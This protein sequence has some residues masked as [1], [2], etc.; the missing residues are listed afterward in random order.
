[1]PGWSRSS[2]L[3]KRQLFIREAPSHIE[4]LF[5]NERRNIQRAEIAF[6][7]ERLCKRTL[8]MFRRLWVII[9]QK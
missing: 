3:A 7:L 2:H 4:L 9:W 5:T 1:M 8:A 6:T